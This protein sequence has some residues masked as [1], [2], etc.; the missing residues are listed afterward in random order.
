VP[1]A[2]PV[3]TPEPVPITATDK[4]E[5]LHTP[6]GDTLLNV[7]VLPSQTAEVPVIG[8]GSGLMVTIA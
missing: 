6:P 2:I 8:D 4:T 5:L 3:T 1:A 7:V